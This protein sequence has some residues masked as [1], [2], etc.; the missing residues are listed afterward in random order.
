MLYGYKSFSLG[1]M[2]HHIYPDSPDYDVHSPRGYNFF[3]FLISPVKDTVRVV[4]RAYYER[5]GKN[6]LTEKKI[7]I[8]IVLF[9][10]SVV[11][12]V[13]FLFLLLGPKLFVVFYLPLYI[14]NLF[15]FAHINFVTH[16]LN[17]NGDYEVVNLNHNI[18]YKVVNFLSCG[19]YFH[20]SH[21]EKPQYLNPMNA[22]LSNK[23]YITYK[24]SKHPCVS[25]HIL[26]NDEVI[27]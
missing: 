5:F 14:A 1:H 20:K 8:Q 26:T 15:V 16:R 18:Y 9:Q 3:S 24:E 17:D 6:E 4:Q 10:L 2:F 25:G 12:K 27:V 7:K 22:P 21:H 23:S 13:I 11:L 19:G